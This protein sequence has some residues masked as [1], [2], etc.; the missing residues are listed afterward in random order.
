M[1]GNL[2][3]RCGSI[4]VGLKFDRNAKIDGRSV[5]NRD[6][7]IILAMPWQQPT[8]IGSGAIWFWIYDGKFRAD[9]IDLRDQY[10]VAASASHDQ[11]QHVVFT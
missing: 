7:Q 10:A 3:P 1:P 11:W 2:D 4:A 8:R 5:E 9:V 6:W